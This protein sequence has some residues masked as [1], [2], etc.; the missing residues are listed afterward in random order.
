[1]KTG[2]ENEGSQLGLGA[3][4]EPIIGTRAFNQLVKIG[5]WSAKLGTYRQICK[6][7]TQNGIDSDIDRWSEI[8]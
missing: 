4:E 1:M 8:H 5:Q 6:F 3:N 2:S 7:D